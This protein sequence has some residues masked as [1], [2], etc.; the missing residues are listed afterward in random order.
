M[1]RLRGNNAG[2]VAR[3]VDWEESWEADDNLPAVS[4][5]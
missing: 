4:W 1:V 5:L 3:L 2:L